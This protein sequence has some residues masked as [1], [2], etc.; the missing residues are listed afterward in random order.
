MKFPF[1]RA[2]VIH[3]KPIGKHSQQTVGKSQWTQVNRKKYWT[4]KFQGKNWMTLKL[5][6]FLEQFMIDTFLI[7]LTQLEKTGT[8]GKIYFAGKFYN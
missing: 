8:I 7:K 3:R 4:S 5:F 6:Q 1:K 2:N